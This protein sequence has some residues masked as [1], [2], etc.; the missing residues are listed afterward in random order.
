MASKFKSLFLIFISWIGYITSF[1][2]PHIKNMRCWRGKTN[3]QSKLKNMKTDNQP[4]VFK[5]SK[6]LKWDQ[7]L[8]ELGKDS[9]VFAVLRADARTAETTIMIEFPTA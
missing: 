5:N 9:P 4:A 1:D 7:M 8:P 6:D 2:W 3:Q